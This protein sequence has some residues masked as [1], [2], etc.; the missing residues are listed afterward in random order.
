MSQITT[1]ILDTSKGKPASGV[2]VVLYSGNDAWA[3]IARGATNN[4]G[5]VTD[6]LRKDSLLETGIYKLRFETKDYF[7]K[8]HIITFYP[9]VEIVFDV[10]DNEHYHVPLLLNPFGYSTYRGS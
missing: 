2:T 9:F 10:Q 5:R 6:L 1:H 3:E 7:E 8:Q 4:D